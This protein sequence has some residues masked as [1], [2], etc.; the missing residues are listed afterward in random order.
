MVHGGRFG[1]IGE[2]SAVRAASS[3]IGHSV[4]VSGM[5]ELDR[6]KFPRIGSLLTRPHGFDVGVDQCSVFVRSE[7][8]TAIRVACIC[9]RMGSICSKQLVDDFLREV[10]GHV[11]P[12]SADAELPRS[13][14]IANTPVL[15]PRCE[16]DSIMRLRA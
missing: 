2:R 16:Q 8:R 5:Q 13:R 11:V 3:W 10:L 12:A 15:E 9:A 7:R 6:S 4:W 14:P 1:D